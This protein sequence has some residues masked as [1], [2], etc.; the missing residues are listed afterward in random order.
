MD[1]LLIRAVEWFGNY[2][3]GQRVA[4]HFADPELQLFIAGD[5]FTES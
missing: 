3:V 2:V 4:S 5:V 1:P